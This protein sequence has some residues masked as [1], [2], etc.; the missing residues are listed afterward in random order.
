MEGLD[1][2]SVSL[3]T[4]EAKWEGKGLQMEEAILELDGELCVA[5]LI[6]NSTCEPVHLSSGDTLGQI[7]PVTIV[8]EPKVVAASLEED[9]SNQHA[10][11]CPQF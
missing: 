10:A 1:H 5:V 11:Y 6:L 8:P 7:Q 3:L 9:T 4:P 2:Q